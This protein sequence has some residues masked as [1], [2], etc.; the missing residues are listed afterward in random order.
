MDP[1]T[2]DVI[3]FDGGASPD[4]GPILIALV[5]GSHA[6]LQRLD[7]TEGGNNQ[8]EFRAALAA[9]TYAAEAGLHRPT[10][11]GDSDAV[12]SAL[13]SRYPPKPGRLT[14]LFERCL[15]VE[16]SLGG[17]V[18]Q[19]VP[20]SNPAGQLIQAERRAEKKARRTARW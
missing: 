11:A 8:A 6:R 18:W 7:G 1:P 9:L 4:P 13:G 2:A 3:F 20:R 12:I 10:I 14:G 16:D 5:H 17:A 15:A 19:Q